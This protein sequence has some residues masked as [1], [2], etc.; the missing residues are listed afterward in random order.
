[1]R[2][3]PLQLL[4]VLVAVASVLSS[5]FII[6]YTE[7][8]LDRATAHASSG[9]AGICINRAPIIINRCNETMTQDV[10]FT[11]QLNATDGDGDNLTWIVHEQ[12]PDNQ[13]IFNITEGLIN[14]TPTNDDVGNHTHIIRVDDDNG[15][16]N[17]RFDLLYMFEVL[18][19]N[20]PPYLVEPIPNQSFASGTTIYP[21]FLS[22]YFADPDDDPLTYSFSMG[23]ASA[24]I[25]VTILNDSSVGFTTNA[26]GYAYVIFT[27]TDPYNASADS[28]L[29]Y[30]EA[31][32]TSEPEDA[33]QDTSSGGG[34]GGSYQ[35]PCIPELI[36]LPWSECYPNG[37]QVQTCRDKNGCSES[38]IKFYRNCTYIEEINLT[39]CEEN[40]LCSE[41]G[42]CTLQ[43]VQQRVCEDLNECGTRQHMPPLEQNCTYDPRCDDG[44]M[45]GNETGI[46][47]G[48]NCAPCSILQAPQPPTE[49]EG[50]FLRYFLLLAGA[51]I[52]IALFIIYRERIYEGVA[53]LG[54][55]IARR[56]QKPI[57]LTPSEMRIILEDLALIDEGV[58][59]ERLPPDKAYDKLTATLRKLISFLIDV[60]YEFSLETAK[61]GIHKARLPKDIEVVVSAMLIRVHELER[62]VDHR[63]SSFLFEGTK[64]E[65]RLLVCLTSQATKA[66][67][68]RELPERVITPEMSL[69]EEIEMRMLDVFEA[70][71]F[72]HVDVAKD[73]YM[74]I[75]RAYDNLDDAQ[76]AI[77]HARIHRLYR[78][79]I[80]LI[81]TAA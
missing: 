64:E 21:F 6:H 44:V 47:C 7:I 2:D 39:P 8:A 16:S 69:V 41:W 13:T 35:P 29:V 30:I 78:E 70:L 17:S 45:N 4:V 18:N 15:C 31:V 12:P 74:N 72:G 76:K 3:R 59:E 55:M 11:C 61:K 37:M 77:E 57:L 46:D 26:C 34:G 22:D 62:V 20:D 63:L 81:E 75:L 36:C 42:P 32:C 14:F 67:V 48:G 23:T 33:T 25:N 5:F 28:N 9:T 68:E 52:T 54:W 40:W 66:D 53:K 73:E 19:V 43:G 79:I 65:T 10:R 58:R 80:Y 71:Q 1:M 50:R 51:I 60:P 38:E 49:A 24:Y 27:A 56:R